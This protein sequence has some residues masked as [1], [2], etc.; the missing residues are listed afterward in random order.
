M[1]E[2]KALLNN[3]AVKK[4]NYFYR[5][6]KFF[7]DNSYKTGKWLTALIKGE[8]KS[9]HNNFLYKT[10]DDN[11]QEELGM[12][13]LQG[14]LW[15][16]IN[17]KLLKMIAKF[18]NWKFKNLSLI[19]LFLNIGIKRLAMVQKTLGTARPQWHQAVMAVQPN[20]LMLFLKHL[21]S[22][23]HSLLHFFWMELSSPY[24][25]TEIIP[26]LKQEK[27]SLWLFSCQPLFSHFWQ[28]QN[29]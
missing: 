17:L 21:A 19:Y 3:I 8:E 24:N 26:I 4:A 10:R 27:R 2:I 11:E 29:A 13:S 25:I 14:T 16:Y 22:S 28:Y 5:A 6:N 23:C 20:F 9:Q 15:D 12:W 1:L 18:G 7:Y